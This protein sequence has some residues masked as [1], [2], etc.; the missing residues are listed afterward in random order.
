MGNN[1][2]KPVAPGESRTFTY[3][4]SPEVGP[5]VSL[6]RDW[7]DVLENP[8][9]GLYGAIVVDP[10]GSTVTGEGA[11]VVVHP[12]G[13]PT[14]RDISLFMQDE[15]DSIG[16]HR[17]PY[18]N[19]VRGT[20]GLNYRTRRSPIDRKDSSDPTRRRLCFRP[21]RATH[22]SSTSWRRGAN[23][24]RRCSPSRVT[25]GRSNRG[26]AARTS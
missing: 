10:V 3:F 4:A 8:K 13:Q 12:K 24:R 5:T 18:T 22:S 20:V 26:C 9:A 21:T 2:F 23:K 1:T 15:D 19:V 7:G 14:Y 17:M 6:V 25:R 16:T 11:Q